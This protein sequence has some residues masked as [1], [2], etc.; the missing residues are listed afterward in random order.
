M[1]C[2]LA[3]AATA[4]ATLGPTTS[5]RADDGK[6]AAWVAGGVLG[7]M[8]LGNAIAN[9]HKNAAPPADAD[10]VPD[11]PPP[12]NCHW[13]RGRPVWDDYYGV[14]RRPRVQVCD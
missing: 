5:A 12:R 9:Q 4:L 13:T 1:I 8:L 14:W 3:V 7:G 2:A 6:T 11:D 10:Y